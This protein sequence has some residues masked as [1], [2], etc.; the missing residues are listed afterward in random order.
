MK[1][2]D[3]CFD[4][5]DYYLNNGPHQVVVIVIVREVWLYDLILLPFL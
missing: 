4:S 5:L 1:S 3:F 2:S